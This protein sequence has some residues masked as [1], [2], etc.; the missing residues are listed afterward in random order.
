M[1]TDSST[2]A[3]ATVA[4]YDLVQQ[5]DVSTRQRLMLLANGQRFSAVVYALAELNVADQ[6]AKGPRPVAELAAAVG[7]DEGALYRLLRCAA[8]LG[9]FTELDGRRFALTPIAE[10]LRTDLPDGVRDAVLLD[11]S[12][13]FWNSFGMILHSAR[14]GRPAFDE[15]YGTSFWTHLNDDPAAG[16]VFDDAMTTISRRLGGLFLDRLDFTRFPR[17]ADVGGGRGYFLAEALRRNP[18]NRGVLFDRPQVVATAPD[19]LA[20]RGVADRVEV[21]GGDFF[22]DALPTGCDGYVLKTV[23]H[24]W[25]DDKAVAILRRVREAI[26]D[27]SGRL[28]VLEQV[29]APGNTWDT[30]KFLDID[31]LVVMGGRERNLDEWRELLWAGGFELECDDD[32]VGWAVLEGRPR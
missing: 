9:V 10:G 11:G 28:L 5:P 26:G 27:G 2:A 19:L 20:E 23:L 22:A 29:V 6:L 12:D 13:F 31:M 32:A 24:D 30:A 17:L 15:R 16:A 8:L 7:A 14:T 21:V 3:S 18:G 25:P 4:G 1:T